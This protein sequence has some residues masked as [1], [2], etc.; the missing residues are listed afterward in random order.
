MAFCGS[1]GYHRR[2]QLCNSHVESDA[3]SITT[4]TGAA[5]FLQGS[6]AT[7]SRL[8]LGL[9]LV[10]YSVPSMK[11]LIT[12]LSTLPSLCSLW[13]TQSSWDTSSLGETF[14]MRLGHASSS[15]L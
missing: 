1:L 11:E 15:T 5:T 8:H 6:A 9:C 3:C 7:P 2:L 13:T 4:G 10:S 12:R 14:L